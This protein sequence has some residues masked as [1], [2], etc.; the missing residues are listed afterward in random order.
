[1]I[2]E[3]G[4]M[5]IAVLVRHGMSIRGIAETTGLSRNTVRRYLRGGDD[6]A[7]RKP[8][9]KQPEK[10]DPFK[11][12]IIDRLKAAAPDM[13][14]AVMLFCEIR[15]RGYE[16]GETRVRDFVYGLRA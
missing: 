14:P 13:I 5:E 4:R 9:P 16:G 12:Y 11:D 2:S 6:V 3:E 7:S 10:R 15:A 8:A 1:M